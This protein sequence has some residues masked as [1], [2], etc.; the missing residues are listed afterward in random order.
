MLKDDRDLSPKKGNAD[1]ADI[2]IGGLSSDEKRKREKGG[3]GNAGNNPSLPRID[4]HKQMHAQD[5]GEAP[6]KEMLMG[7]ITITER[8]AWSGPAGI[9]RN[10]KYNSD[11]IRNGNRGS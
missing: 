4:E 11:M 10:S 9:S 5:V 3:L 1:D 8:E 7:S 6:E 2:I